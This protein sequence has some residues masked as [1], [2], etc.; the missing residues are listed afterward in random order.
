MGQYNHLTY[1][2]RKVIQKKFWQGTKTKIIAEE[3]GVHVS[4][5][6]REIKRNKDDDGMYRAISAQQKY[7]TRRSQKRT[8]KLFK[9][10]KLLLVVLEGL[11]K[12]WSP[13]TISG[14]L[15]VEFPNM[16]EMWISRETIYKII[17]MLYHEKGIE[18]WKLLPRKR[19]KREN[20]EHKRRSRLKIRVKDKKS[21]HERPKE[22]D[23]RETFGHWEG[24]TIVGK[25]HDGYLLT[26]L[27]RKSQL[28][29]SA[30]MPDKSAESCIRAMQEAFDFIGNDMIKTITFDNGTEFSMFKEIEELF[31][32]DVYF[33]DP[34]RPWQRGSNERAN[35]LLRRFYPKGTSFKNLDEKELAKTIEKINSMPRKMLNYLTPYEVFFN[36]FVPQFCCTSILNL[37]TYFLLYKTSPAVYL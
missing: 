17:Y 4:T 24:D 3:L 13:E 12:H 30:C 15:K 18:L 9:N 33:A 11:F 34:Y 14:R 25:G 20:R 6:I 1:E 37:P 10:E 22:V 5:V 21:I 29:L 23:L 31:E 8:P 26:L 32:C 19:K 28:Y 16:P 35:G 36:K 27:E 2:Q 7:N